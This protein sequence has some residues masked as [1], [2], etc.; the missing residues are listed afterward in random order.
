MP[1]DQRDRL[2]GPQDDRDG[3]RVMTHERI[4]RRFDRLDVLLDMLNREE[5]DER[6]RPA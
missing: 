2:H 4:G 1:A 3:G 6:R 5:S